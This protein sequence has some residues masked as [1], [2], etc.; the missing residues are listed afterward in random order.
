MYIIYNYGKCKGWEGTSLE[1][2]EGTMRVLDVIQGNVS[3]RSLEERDRY[4]N[5][6]SSVSQE[7]RGRSEQDM[8]SLNTVMENDRVHIQELQKTYLMKETSLRGLEEI[9]RRIS[10]FEA[11]PDSENDFQ[12][13]SDQ[14]QA[15]IQSTRF[16][17][18]SVISYIS[19]KVT[20][21]KSLYTLKVNLE[22][23]MSNIRESMGEERRKIASFLVQQE[24]IDAA[25][26]Y[27]PD[28]NARKVV[29]AL[30]R[31]NAEQIFRGLNNVQNLLSLEG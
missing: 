24:N 12:R 15:V 9:Q 31:E 1:N 5:A 27:S 25:T 3:V 13:L 2:K 21:E 16:D 8:L 18:E 29:E 26:R 11:N 30:N 6:L 10:G 22:T 19:S 17:G 28:E 4:R 20:D 23:E 7:D 14:L